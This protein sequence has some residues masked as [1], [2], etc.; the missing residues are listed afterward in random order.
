MT[1]RLERRNAWSSEQVNCQASALARPA[2]RAEGAFLVA[3]TS[4]PTD[5]NVPQLTCK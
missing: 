4:T 2:P 1:G 3:P 5:C